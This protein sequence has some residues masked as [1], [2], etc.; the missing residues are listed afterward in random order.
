MNHYV[1]IKADDCINVVEFD[2]AAEA[3]AFVEHS[4]KTTFEYLC[5]ITDKKPK[6]KY[7]KR[8][9]AKVVEAPKRRVGRPRKSETNA[10]A[11]DFS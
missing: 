9:K 10:I 2:S 1:I 5:S 6:R 3:K 8:V 11:G 7:T 4:R